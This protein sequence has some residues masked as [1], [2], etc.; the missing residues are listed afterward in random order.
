VQDSGTKNKKERDKAVFMTQFYPTHWLKKKAAGAGFD[1]FSAIVFSLTCLVTANSCGETG[2][3][4]NNEQ[5]GSKQIQRPP[6]QNFDKS[7][8]EKKPSTTKV[9]LLGTGT[10]VPDPDNSGPS[11]AVV[12]RNRAYLVDFGAG[13]VRRAQTAYLMGVSALD[14]RFLNLAF[15]THLH[16]DHTIGYPDLIFTPATVGRRVPLVVYGPKGLK[17][18]TDNVL[19]AYE[20]DLAVRATARQDRDMNGYKVEVNEIEPGEIYKDEEVKVTAFPVSHGSWPLAFGY[21]FDTSDRSIV[22]SGDTRPAETTIRACSGCDVLIHEVYCTSGFRQGAP[23]WRKYHAQFHTS[24][25]ELAKLAGEA[26]PK[27]LIL[28]HKLYFGCSEE[29]LVNEVRAGYKG[30]VVIGNDLDIY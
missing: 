27:L 26:R 24:S 17:K 20:E 12:T 29:Q 22:I 11:T 2:E 10:P 8:K 25:Q 5:S 30:E 16:S 1:L 3:N 18:M 9:V 28:Y 4:Q 21:R 6:E 7:H 14:V 15:V 13:L 23:G 19:A